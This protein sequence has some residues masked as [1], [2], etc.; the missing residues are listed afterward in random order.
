MSLRHG[1]YLL[2][3]LIA[4]LLVTSG[5]NRACAVQYDVFLDAKDDA[6]PTYNIDAY[7]RFVDRASGAGLGPLNLNNAPAGADQ[8]KKVA[9]DADWQLQ[10]AGNIWSTDTIVGD[11]IH[12]NP[13]SYQIWAVG[14]SFLYDSFSDPTWSTQWNTPPQWDVFMHVPFGDYE[15]GPFMPASV[16]GNTSL[17][18]DLTLTDATDLWFWIKDWNSIDNSGGL[19]LSIVS[20]PEPSPLILLAAGLFLMGFLARKRLVR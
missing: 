19:K 1:K 11:S 7:A 16:P 2:L 5:N 6:G 18:Y 13:G 12:L 9:P 17:H 4:F 3:L 14:G 20:V 10:S 8:I 15:F